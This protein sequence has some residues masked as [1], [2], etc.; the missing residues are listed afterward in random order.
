MKNKEGESMN[1]V[2]VYLFATL[3]ER[4]GV[5]EIQLEVTDG[6]LVRDVK[7]IL[8]ERFPGLAGVMNTALVAVNHE[9]AQDD[10]AIPQ[11]AEIALFP[12]VSGGAQGGGSGMELGRSDQALLPTVFA[13]TE[14][15]LDLNSLL[16]QITLPTSGAA[17]FFY[18]HGARRH[19]P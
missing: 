3:K 16:A 10:V 1:Y 11:N 12:P 17:C 5:K 18:G 19:S 9:Y 7:K 4:A 13:I 15:E 14:E 2:T 6:A 8:L